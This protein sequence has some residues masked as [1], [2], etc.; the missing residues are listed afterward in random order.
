MNETVVNITINVLGGIYL[1]MAWKNL[2][3]QNY[4]IFTIYIILGF[5]FLFRNYFEEWTPESL[6]ASFSSKICQKI[7]FQQM[8]DIEKNISEEFCICLEE[9]QK[10]EVITFLPCGC[11][12][13]FHDP[14]IKE[15]L[16]KS[17]TCPSCRQE[18]VDVDEFN[19]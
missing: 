17:L 1:W 9:F 13:I 5:R 3:K 10:E 6:L 14:C 18:V 16:K 7:K 15:W 19:Y 8:K 4:F 11:F 2:I 12:Q